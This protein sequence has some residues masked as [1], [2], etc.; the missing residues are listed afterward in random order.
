MSVAAVVALLAILVVPPLVSV[1]R[2]K[3]QIT[4]LISRSLGRPVRLSSVHVRLLPRPG[5]VLYDLVV[6]DNPAFGAEPVIHASSVT[7]PIRIWSLWRGRL[8]ISAISVDEASLNLVRTPDGMWNLDSLLETTASNAGKTNADH[9]RPPAPFPRLEATNSRINFK[10]GVEKLPFS[11]I[12]TDLSFWQSNPGEWR[13]QLRGQ[14]A[15]TDLSINAADTGIVEIDAT[16]HQAADLR[17]MPLHFDLDWRD[18]QLGQLTRLLTGSDAGWRGDLRGE[19]HLDGTLENAQIKT[20]LRATGVHRAE[21]APAAP[22]DFDANCSLMYHYTRRTVENLACD[23]PLGS[24]RIRVTGEMSGNGHLP[25]Y[26]VEMDHVPVGAGLEALRT[27]RSGVDPSLT[28]VGT[29]S[30]KVSYDETPI[31][32][33]AQ[34]KT[35][36][37]AAPTSH[38]K[39]R[40]AKPSAPTAEPLKGTFTVEGFQLNGGGF[41]TPLTAPKIEIAP[42]VAVQGHDQQLAGTFAI[43]AGAPVPLTLD[44]H[45]AFRSYEVTARGQVSVRRAREIASATGLPNAAALDQL[46]GDP[47]A[48]D[49]FAQGP[50]L[51]TQNVFASPSQPVLAAN[52]IARGVARTAGLGD[53]SVPTVD[54]LSGTVRVHNA[55]W[56][57]NYLASPVEISESTLHVDNGEIRWDPINFAFG[58]LKGSATLTVPKPCNPEEP[59]EMGALPSFYV[60]FGSLD[61][62]TVQTAILGAHEKGTLLSDLLNR[63]RP[64]AAPVWPSME[65]TVTAESLILGPVTLQEVQAQLHIAATGIE[66]MTLDG[67]MLGGTMHANGTLVTG[68]KPNYR[69]SAVFQKLNPTAVGQMLGQTWRGGAFEANGKIQLAGYTVSDLVSSAKGSLHFDWSRGV[70]SPPTDLGRFDRWAGNAEIANGKVT[71]GLNEVARGSRK[72]AVAASV[73]LARP[74]KLSFATTEPEKSDK[75][76]PAAKH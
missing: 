46:T 2:Y 21:F 39:T 37:G 14:P 34:T 70:A 9:G 62:A 7:A 3:G 10:R 43:S 49:L 28:A 18:A 38:A 17:Q 69:L 58:P 67:K 71:I 30:G 32:V 44:L 54:S 27:V 66:I 36:G 72:H 19:V 53:A 16:A 24:G 33:N 26:S 48:V 64:S 42:T 60:G 25:R 50:W 74:V 15:R 57:A 23:S 47:L 75:P 1:S 8:E 5:F 22:M 13:I 68:D 52:R 76:A 20:R 41:S 40:V 65:G 29:I 63:L 56:K 51:P 4:N 31:P 6:D 59:C 35:H 73:A 11:L 45:L 61:A 12:D 55:S